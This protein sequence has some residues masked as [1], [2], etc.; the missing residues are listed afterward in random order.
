[1]LA[2]HLFEVGSCEFS[3]HMSGMVDVAQR[4]SKSSWNKHRQIDFLLQWG[5]RK[6]VSNILYKFHLF[7]IFQQASQVN[8]VFNSHHFFR[9]VTPAI[10]LQ[11]SLAKARQLKWLK[12]PRPWRHMVEVFWEQ[13]SISMLLKET[14]W[15]YRSGT[16]SH[17]FSKNRYKQI[18]R[19]VREIH[20]LLVESP[21]GS[22]RRIFMKPC[23]SNPLIGRLLPLDGQIFLQGS[24]WRS[25][26]KHVEFYI[27]AAKQTFR[28]N[29]SGAV[30]GWFSM[31]ATKDIYCLC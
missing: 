16:Y 15:N 11:A 1:M 19:V 21:K 28:M 22:I 5:R 3:W 7:R 31:S 10:A 2:R 9:H 20:P 6:I 4:C 25:S 27:T 8:I 23:R 29:T 13:T 12:Y 17:F 30:T 18:Q 26:K 24:K 14:F